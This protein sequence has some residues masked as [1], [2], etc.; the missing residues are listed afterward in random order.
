MLGLLCSLAGR[1]L[2]PGFWLQG[3]GLLL[4][5]WEKAGGALATHPCLQ[6]RCSAYLSK[7]MAMGRLRVGAGLGAW[8]RLKKAEASTVQQQP[9][10]GSLCG[11]SHKQAEPCLTC[12]TQRT[13]GA[14]LGA[15]PYSALSAAC[16][17]R[18]SGR[19]RQARQAAMIESTLSQS[20]C[21]VRHCTQEMRPH[22]GCQPQPTSVVIEVNSD[23]ARKLPLKGNLVIS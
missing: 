15:L 19:A 17:A 1:A 7:S 18:H 9:G 11:N 8:P 3:F 13:P 21:K 16:P 5:I 20:D 2:V 22:C 10:Q 14:R 12:T 4:L 6:G 23:W